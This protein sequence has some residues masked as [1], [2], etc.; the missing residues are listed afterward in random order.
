MSNK[1]SLLDHE[2]NEMAVN[3]CNVEKVLRGCE[4]ILGMGQH[5]VPRVVPRS[6]S[7]LVGWASSYRPK[8]GWVETNLFDYEHNIFHECVHYS[9]HQE[10]LLMNEIVDEDDSFINLVYA[11][12]IDETVAELAT[13]SVWGYES[14]SLV[15]PVENEL[16]DALIEDLGVERIEELVLGLGKSPFLDPDYSVAIRLVAIQNAKT[17]QLTPSK[18]VDRIKDARKRFSSPVEIYQAIKSLDDRQG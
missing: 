6:E 17:L 9:M 11:H 10:K 16:A 15:P 1:R 12:L 18:L 7:N 2:S 4:E 8:K 3:F 13:Y 5:D 14:R